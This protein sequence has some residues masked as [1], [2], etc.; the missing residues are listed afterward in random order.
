MEHYPVIPSNLLN[1]ADVSSPPF[2]DGLWDLPT[3]G[4]DVI[5]SMRVNQALQLNAVIPKTF[6]GTFC[7][8]LRILARECRPWLPAAR[9]NL[10]LSRAYD[11]LPLSTYA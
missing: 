10:A 1:L 7:G 9:V 11:I 3:R 6:W 5:G 2:H 8:K 4:I